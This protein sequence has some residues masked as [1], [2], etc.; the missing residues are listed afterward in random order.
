MHYYWKLDCCALGSKNKLKEVELEAIDSIINST[1]LWF[2]VCVLSHLSLP[3]SMCNNWTLQWLTV[4]IY[5]MPV[6]IMGTDIVTHA[7]FH[8]W[9]VNQM[10]IKIYGTFVIK[11]KFLPL[12]CWLNQLQSCRY[13]LRLLPLHQ[14]ENQQMDSEWQQN[15]HVAVEFYFVSSH[16]CK[17]GKKFSQHLTAKHLLIRNFGTIFNIW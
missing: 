6:V 11:V 14:V 1:V 5:D 12:D 4:H 2:N 16:L 15:C 17:D 9:D 8:S 7:L 13:W 10:K 3:K